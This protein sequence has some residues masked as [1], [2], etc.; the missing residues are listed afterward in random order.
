MLEIHPF[1]L[2]LRIDEGGAVRVG[3]TRV[4]LEIVI[5]SFLEGR[6]PESIVESFDTLDLGDVYTVIGY[7]LRFRPEVDAY[8]QECTREADR[9]QMEIEARPGHNAL[10]EKVLAWKQK[11]AA[12]ER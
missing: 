1:D 2:P 10:R 11:L 5:E 6:S 9:L 12:S 3:K 8:L 4:T 7:Y